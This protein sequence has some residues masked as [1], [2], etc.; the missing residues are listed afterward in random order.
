MSNGH[1]LRFQDRVALVTGGASG[2]GLAV[3]D[4]LVREGARVA[5]W[6]ID[7]GKLARCHAR[8]GDRVLVQ[9]VDVGDAAA[10]EAAM[11]ETVA[12][13][14][15]LDILVNGAGIV[16]PNGPFWETEVAQ[17]ERVVR[18]NLTGSFLASRA[19]T[20][21]L[22]HNGWGRIVNIASVTAN[23]GPRHL[24]PYAATKAGVVGLT[25]SMGKDLAGSG[26]LVNAITP[27]LI[28]TELL[29][30][31]TPEYMAAALARIPLGRPGTLDEAAALV[32][33][34]C[35]EECSF[36]TGASYDLSGGRGV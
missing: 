27:A 21:H 35:S 36:S 16:G 20:P 3:V 15:R 18:I 34:L 7:G 26:V 14:Q 11:V 1:S 17:W 23:E 33:W 6:D 12:R 30:Q 24:G 13:W 29:E 31:L 8:H 28:A 22:R 10:I 19:A 5:V 9:T 2:I 32:T 25:K 4:R